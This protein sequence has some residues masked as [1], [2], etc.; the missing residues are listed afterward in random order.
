MSRGRHGTWSRPNSTT[1]LNKLLTKNC[2]YFAE[3]AGPPVP[4]PPGSCR[5]F[6][7]NP[8]PEGGKAP[9]PPP[10]PSISADPAGRLASSHCTPN[11]E[12]RL[13]QGIRP[14]TKTKR[15]HDYRPPHPRWFSGTLPPTDAGH[16]SSVRPV[17]DALS[18]RTHNGRDLEPGC[19][20]GRFR[21]ASPRRT[22]EGRIPFLI[23][24][25]TS[26]KAIEQTNKPKH[27]SSSN[28]PVPRGRRTAQ[29][30][31]ARS[32]Q[33]HHPHRPRTLTAHPRHPRGPRTTKGLHSGTRHCPG[34]RL[35]AGKRAQG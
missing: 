34:I 11:P 31:P 30:G 35:Q 2:A 24:E 22:R 15:Y 3:Y 1:D 19:R 20:P 14:D 9:F 17:P 29:G 33:R 10:G 8:R 25:Q 7:A 13:T 23:S 28:Q 12:R 16:G 5:I 26:R 4:S 18:V 6:A 32:R 21:R 27:L